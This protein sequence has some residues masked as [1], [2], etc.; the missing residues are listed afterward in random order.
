M[1]EGPSPGPG[2]AIGLGPDGQL[3]VPDEP[4][5]PFL[6]GDGVGPDIW[7]AARPVLDTAVEKAYGGQ[8]KIHWLEVFWG[9][10]ARYLL[11]NPLP[12]ETISAIDRH[13]V[14]LRGPLAL[15]PSKL[16]ARS[17]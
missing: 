5:V 3:Q 7:A 13:H 16:M 10:K 6:E 17:W 2:G 15:S 4:I 1:T 14:A 9:Q 8:R 12:A 11:G